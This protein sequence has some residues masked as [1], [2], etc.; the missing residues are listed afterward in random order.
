M[1]RTGT[2]RLDQSISQRPWSG[3]GYLPGPWFIP[4]AM[5]GA[6]KSL[7]YHPTRF[8]IKCFPYAVNLEQTRKKN[9]RPKIPF[10]DPDVYFDV[11]ENKTTSKDYGTIL[12]FKLS[13][14]YKCN[15][16]LFG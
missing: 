1:I 11:K 2:E 13:P 9:M 4:K 12:V 15:L 8:T 7:V 3:W 5:Y 14:Y 10:G 16:F 6:L